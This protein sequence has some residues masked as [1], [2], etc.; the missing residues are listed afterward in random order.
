MLPADR[1][2]LAGFGVGVV[3]R[4]KALDADRPEPGDA[5]VAM[6]STG[7][8]VEGYE[9]ARRIVADAGL[10]LTE[11]HGLR[12]QSLGDAL[13]RPS[14]IY[15]RACLALV[16]GAA[17]HAL[18]RVGEGG[19]AGSLRRV[20]PE[21][22]GAV[23]DAQTFTSPGIFG[24]LAEHGGVGPEEMWRTFNMGAGMLAVV[25]DGQHAVEVLRNHGVDAWVCGDV[26]E[27]TGVRVGGLA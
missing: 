12:V 7:L 6:A 17:V 8:H 22:L 25:V 2:D 16:R 9:L 3:D 4:A 20:L 1:Y 23:V 27:T 10:D 24:L 18:C 5:V 13:L 21:G 26:R 11:D 19:V 15:A 14:R